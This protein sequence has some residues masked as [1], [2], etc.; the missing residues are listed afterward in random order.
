MIA[1]EEEERFTGAYV[2]PLSLFASATAMITSVLLHCQRMAL[3]GWC[4]P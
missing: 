3:R 1:A 2:V 4:C